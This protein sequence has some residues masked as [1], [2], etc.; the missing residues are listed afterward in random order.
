[1]GYPHTWQLRPL[2][3]IRTTDSWHS[4]KTR[5]TTPG[6]KRTQATI[7]EAEAHRHD[8]RFPQTWIVH[9]KII[10][11][12]HL[13]LHGNLWGIIEQMN[14]FYSSTWTQQALGGR[15]VSPTIQ[16]CWVRGWHIVFIDNRYLQQIHLRRDDYHVVCFNFHPVGWSR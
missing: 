16:R 9:A 5:S 14:R 6:R 1:M 13:L 12:M 15:K 8:P 7:T 3:S 11:R 2:P 4:S 10:D